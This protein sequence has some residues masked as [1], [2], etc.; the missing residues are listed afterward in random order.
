MYYYNM[1]DTTTKCYY[2]TT[3]RLKSRTSGPSAPSRSK[4][5]TPSNAE[6]P[7]STLQLL[8]IAISNS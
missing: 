6:H 5:G 4:A 7:H 3:T 2:V 1:I 8:I